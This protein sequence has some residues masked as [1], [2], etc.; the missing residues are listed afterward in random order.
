MSDASLY[1]KEYVSHYSPIGRRRPPAAAVAA[2][3][4]PESAE[5]PTRAQAYL[6]AVSQLFGPSSA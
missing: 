4:K 1:R 5:T 3:H 2:L 6:F